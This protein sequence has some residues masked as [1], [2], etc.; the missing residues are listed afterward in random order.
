MTTFAPA[1]Q[2]FY[3]S[4]S[5]IPQEDGAVYSLLADG[6]YDGAFD[7]AD[8]ALK[9]A[10]TKEASAAASITLAHCQIFTDTDQAQVTAGQAL[11]KANALGNSKLI[12]AAT[13]MLAKATMLITPDE[14]LATA[15]TA[16]SLARVEQDAF[17][18][19]L[20]TY[21]QASVM[22][23]AGYGKEAFNFAAELTNLFTDDAVAR[24]CAL[25]CAAEVASNAEQPKTALGFAKDAA[26]EFNDS[27]AMG[28]EALATSTAAK[29]ALAANST[30]G[31]D[32][33]EQAFEL[34]K[35]VGDEKGP[36]SLKVALAEHK[37]KSD[38]LIVAEDLAEEALKGCAAVGD[39][40]A[41]AEAYQVLASVRLALALAEA[42]ESGDD[43]DAGSATE[44][45]RYALAACRKLGDKAGQAKAS[46]KLSLIRYEC[47]ALDTAKMGTEEA[48]ALF[49]ELGDANGEADAMLLAARVLQAEQQFDAAKRQAG[50]ASGLYER[51]GNKEG[52]EACEDFMNKN[53]SA[54]SDFKRD[55]AAEKKK[56]G[57][58]T[59][60]G[61]VKL[62]NNA[63]EASHLL[64][65]FAEMDDNEDTELSEFDLSAWGNA[66]MITVK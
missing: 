61:L 41:E 11:E 39:E 8:K 29:A 27:N 49:R 30:E 57:S 34:Y 52:M 63:E 36:I 59:K 40:V 10:G 3:E 2:I 26:K 46:Y 6:D 65:Y 4:V 38:D 23:V 7:Q 37:L 9:K 42:K 16:S 12:A 56:E 31:E 48:Q 45:A 53:K 55:Q 20:C 50:K 22:A 66:G 51:V 60:S 13:C 44:A 19:A 15:K 5:L 18:E 58:T 47:G 54:Q 43:P 1:T 62:V 14:A 33:A 17:L 21:T 64:S 24:G 28:K 25:L 32:L 35:T